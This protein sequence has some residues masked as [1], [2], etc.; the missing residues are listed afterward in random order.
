[1]TATLKN[2]SKTASHG[3]GISPTGGPIVNEVFLLTAS[4]AG[5]EVIDCSPTGDTSLVRYCMAAFVMPANATASGFEGDADFTGVTG[6]CEITDATGTS[7]LTDLTGTTS[8][9]TCELTSGA[10]TSEVTD[11]TGTVEVTDGTGTF[12]SNLPY[13]VISTTTTPNDTVT[14]NNTIEDGEYFV[15]LVGRP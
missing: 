1:M 2:V 7:T 11:P 12:S 13:A 10:G 15:M 6:T 14:I 5:S 3:S 9:G 8:D 4:N